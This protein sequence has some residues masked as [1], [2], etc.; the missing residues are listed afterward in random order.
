[1]T[2]Q[3]FKRKW[4]WLKHVVWV[5]AA[6]ILLVIAVVAFFFG[7]GAANPLLRRL[8]VS[9][10]NLMTGGR[11]ELRTL[12]IGWFSWRATVK[13]LVIHGHEP[14]GT[15]PL[16]SAEEVQIGLRIDSF[17]GR[18]IALDELIV[19]QPLLHVRVGKDGKSNVPEP[20]RSLTENKPLR[21]RLFDLHV[22]R[23][24]I[25][26]GWML[27]NDIRTPM[28]LE[29]GDLRLTLDT[30]NP[31][32]TPLY[33]GELNFQSMHFT[34]LRF[35]PVPMDVDAK[36]TLWRGGIT[37]EQAI[38]SA[39]RSRVDGQ[40]EMNGFT[41]PQ[42]KFRYRAWVDLFDV[43]ETTRE[44]L[45]PTGVV[46]VRGE[47]AL[48][49][50]KYQ[51]RGDYF[52][53]S[54]VLPYVQ[55]HT[56][57][58]NSRGSYRMD[59][60]GLV[61]PDFY[62]GAFGGSVTG[63]VTMRFSDSRFRAETH[64]KNVRLAEA[65][66]AAEE[67][68]FPVK[69]LHWD[70][71]LTA[72]T[73]EN[74]T[75]PFQHFDIKGTT[76]WE[77]PE[78]LA[79]GDKPIT[80]D[81][82]FGWVADPNILTIE[83]G[84]FVT[85]SMSATIS[86]I[87]APRHS[88]LNIKLDTTALEADR[89]FINKIQG[90]EPG[91]HEATMPLSGALHWDGKIVGPLGGPTF[92]GHLRGEHIQYDATT[93]DELEGDL[94]YSAEQLALTNGRAHRG[95]METAI[96]AT[97]QLTD[98][99]FRPENAWTAE[100]SMEKTRVDD[101][102][103][104]LH[105]NYPV[106]GL[107]SGQFH[108]RGTRSQPAVTGL[109]DLADATAYGLSFNRLRGQIN[110]QPDEIRIADAELRFFAP[111]TEASR[112]AG[113]VTGSVTYRF[114]DKTVS[115]ELV[116]AS[117]PLE[118]IQKL[119]STRFPLG[120]QLSFRL[121]AN[122]P[123]Q[124]P[125]GE[126]TVRLVDLRVGSEVLGSFDGE[127]TSDGR[128]AQL[129]LKSAMST[130]T[131]SGTA[132]LGLAA[133][134]PLSGRASIANINLDPFLLTALHL[135]EFSGHGEAAGDIAI[136]GDLKNSE[137][138]VVGA[139]LSHL[140][141]NYENVRLENSGPIQFRSSHD[142][143]EIEPATLRGTDTNLQIAGSVGFSGRRAVNLRL[144]GDLDLR[145][146]SG[147]VQQLDARGA[148]QINA[149]FEGT[150]DR[151]RITGKVHVD[152]ASV[153][154]SDFPTGLSSIKGDLIFD[155]TRAFF[156]GV[157][158]E[159]GGGVLNLAGS[160]SYADRP[161]RFDISVRTDRVRIRYPEG[162][163]W[164]V[165]GTLRLTGTPDAGL[166]SGKVVVERVNLSQGVENAA[167]LFSSGKEGI[168]GPSTGSSFL[169]N[170]QFDIVGQSAPDARMEWP[171][172]ELEADADVR[173]RGTWEHPIMLGHVHILSGDLF[174]GG[175]R[176][177]VSR[178]D[179][180]FAD[181]FRLDPVLNV[182][183]TT[184]IQQYEVTLDFSGPSSKLSLSYRSDPPLPGNDIITLLA[185]GQ[186]SSEATSRSAG[187]QTNAG[188]TALLSEAISSQLGGRLERLFGITRFRVDPGLTT[189][190]STATDQNPAARVTVEQ[191]VS[192]NLTITYVSNVGS[193]QQQVIQVEYNV[194][195]NVS[196]VA[197]RDYNGTF[198]ID[199][200]IKKRFK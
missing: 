99:S 197:L 127:L 27:Y 185:L 49:N 198:G 68:N 160:V 83:D 74:W 152:N 1:M 187:A 34:T 196:V 87:L 84:T 41:D 70:G 199:V 28:A 181:P 113:I 175:N 56:P 75:G 144:N 30:S 180:N 161:L 169:R 132:S 3:P 6:N 146:L 69:E 25:V 192:R 23:V 200:V 183:A 101:V 15:E 124:A 186:T 177:R 133:P 82:Q 102:Q 155:A 44:P 121:K 33:L 171:S 52:G 66:V 29:G 72:D 162:M 77:P 138:L 159:V 166:L 13:G 71:V 100:A 19:R 158:A 137:S 39:G 172:A 190:G 118:N 92:Q 16:F 36:F 120:G 165:G 43:R 94:T 9:R 182:E 61:V 178:G 51:G 156:Q 96:G 116:G 22:R 79:S 54:I 26:D 8:V 179:I 95:Q 98:W 59:N 135:K 134:F 110:L 148:A 176:Y 143:L 136:D 78:T 17:W 31:I 67:I 164:L 157:T 184:T 2:E 4:R 105:T 14:A 40:A 50:G 141:L 195:R 115:A 45:V 193:T 88:D 21:E 170:L 20:Q 104:L 117:L 108:G 38:I 194:N 191:Q 128:K 129:Q 106:D 85:P 63:R 140:V 86:G 112:G 48:A 189:I 91:S 5:L 131:L 174:F 81:W 10:I 167:A 173:V 76:H 7:S 47:G 188:A 126:G 114:A 109:F 103:Q 119:Q 11:T 150:M 24:E 58:L 139:K 93:L 147:I 163:S 65:L 168:Y 55:F 142:T 35:S 62:A 37:V 145:L 97:L 46:D 122:G 73:V 153:R 90:A 60:Q 125:Q 107:L 89:D 32:E 80:A 64:A 18:R 57:N 151:P 130:G 111:G 12:S 154:A 42:W 149:S 53:Q 123:A